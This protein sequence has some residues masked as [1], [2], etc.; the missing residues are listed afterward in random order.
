M[1]RPPLFDRAMIVAERVRRHRARKRQ[2][3]P[4]LDPAPSETDLRRWLI[5]P[6]RPEPE[7]PATPDD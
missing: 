5:W 2:A 3:Q 7:I 1:P 4:P 6:D